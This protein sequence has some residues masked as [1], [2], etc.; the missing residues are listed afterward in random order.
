MLLP[1]RLLSNTPFIF[2]MFKWCEVRDCSISSLSLISET[3]CHSSLDK[4]LIIANLDGW[5][6]LLSM[7]AAFSI[8]CFCNSVCSPIRS[9][10]CIYTLCSITLQE[11]A[12]FATSTY[13]LIQSAINLINCFF[14][15]FKKRVLANSFTITT[16]LKKIPCL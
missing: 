10:F 15:C 3:A 4:I 16:P 11:D 7:N 8:S 13:I 14:F 1:S 12:L 2:M 9:V 6:I 5:A